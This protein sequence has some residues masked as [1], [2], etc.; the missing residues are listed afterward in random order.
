[1]VL[2]GSLDVV[3]FYN[4][5]ELLLGQEIIDGGVQIQKLLLRLHM[6]VVSCLRL[7]AVPSNGVLRQQL[8]RYWF[9]FLLHPHVVSIETH[10]RVIYLVPVIEG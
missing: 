7:H 2:E 10:A 9:A 8:Q 6:I 4:V 1:V 3:W 5:L